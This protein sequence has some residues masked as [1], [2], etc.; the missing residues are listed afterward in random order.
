MKKGVLI[1]LL[2]LSTS[3]GVYATGGIRSS[4]AKQKPKQ[5]AAKKQNALGMKN[6]IAVRKNQL[7]V[8]KNN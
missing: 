7:A 1:A 5:N 6:Q 3:V 8:L 2:A 4:K